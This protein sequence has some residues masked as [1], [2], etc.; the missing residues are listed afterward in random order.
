MLD[1]LIGV[2]KLDSNTFEE[3]EHDQ[4][5]TGEAAIVVAVV[6]LLAAIGGGVGAAVIGNRGFVGSFVSTLIWVFVAWI[7]W[8]VVTY[9][10]GTAI[11]GGKADMGEMLRVTGYA[12][13]PQVLAIIPCIG[14]IIGLIWTLA[15][16][17]VAARQ[18]LDL[19][20]TKTAVTL[21]VGLIVY[22]IGALILNLL[23]AGLGALF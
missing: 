4:N 18:G 14:W 9:I 10:V 5:A 2:F 17:L 21:V 16:L 23:V 22:L 11:F 6:A 7:V 3:I 8:S 20:N 19:D 1:R 13:A 12:F 15:A